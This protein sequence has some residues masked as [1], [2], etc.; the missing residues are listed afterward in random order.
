VVCHEP[1]SVAS[2][3]NPA[4]LLGPGRQRIG[5]LEGAGIHRSIVKQGV[6]QSGYSRVTQPHEV[7]SG[8]PPR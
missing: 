8:W 4:S 6:E 5:G 7:S 2:L 3:R 1:R